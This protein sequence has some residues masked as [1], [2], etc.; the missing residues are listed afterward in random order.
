M[1]RSQYILTYMH[2][3]IQTSYSRKRGKKGNIEQQL[4]R[5]EL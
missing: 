3:Y 1:G 2:A 5:Y 4:G